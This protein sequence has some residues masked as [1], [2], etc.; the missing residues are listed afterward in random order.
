M[1]TRPVRPGP[2]AGSL[3]ARAGRFVWVLL[4]MLVAMKLGML[5]WENRK[6]C[7]A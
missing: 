4:Q 3:A 7:H 6:A 1:D 5:I 2:H